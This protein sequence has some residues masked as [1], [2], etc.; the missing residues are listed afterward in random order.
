MPNLTLTEILTNQNLETTQHVLKIAMRATAEMI[1]K[2]R[3]LWKKNRT[4]QAAHRII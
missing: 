2:P 3:A 1:S 4:R